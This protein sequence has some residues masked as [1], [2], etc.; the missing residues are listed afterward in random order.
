MYDMRAEYREDA[1]I[2]KFHSINIYI[3]SRDGERHGNEMFKH[4]RKQEM[5]TN[6]SHRVKITPTQN[7]CSWV[8]CK[9]VYLFHDFKQIWATKQ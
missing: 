7:K 1:E 5:R 6:S 2:N 4:G 9:C 3:Y 8:W